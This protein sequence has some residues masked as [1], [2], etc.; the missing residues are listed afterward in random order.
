MDN[1]L[2]TLQTVRLA[3]N[4]GPRLRDVTLTVRPGVTAVMGCSGAGKT[5]LLNL[6]VDYERADSGTVL[7]HVERG[8][9]SL[10]VF[11]VPQ[12]GGLWPH[13]TAA[14]HLHAV[15][16]AALPH[17]ELGKLLT[18]FDLEHCAGARPDSLSMG[19]RSRLSVARAVAADAAALV[20]DEPLLHLDHMRAQAY[21]RRLRRHCRNS[22]T[23]LVF[24]THFP[25]AVLG[26]ADRVICLRE[27][28][29]LY[30]G[31]VDDLYYRPETQE[32][33]ECLGEVNWLEPRH[34]LL[35]LP[36]GNSK[37][38]CYRPEHI[39][40]QIAA[41]GPLEV[42]RQRFHGSV[43]R[44]TLSHRKTGKTRTFFHRPARDILRKGMRVALRLLAVL[45]IAFALN[46][47]REAEEPELAVAAVRHWS[48]PPEGA[49]IPG[50][51]SIAI[52]PDGEA[53]VLDT[54]GRVLIFEP[55][56][57]LRTQWR[58]PAVER[59][60]PEGVCVL[61]DGR[62]AVC[63]THYHRVLFFDVEGN[64]AGGFGEEGR[65]PGQFIYPVGIVQ[66]DEGDLYICEYGG[67][68]RVQKFT[69]DG[70]LLA[71]FGSSGPGPGEFQRP[72]GLAW[73]DG[74]LLVADAVNNRI[75]AFSEDGSL[76]GPIGGPALFD[77]P[78]GVALAPDGGLFVVEYGGGCVRRL[79]PDGRVVA[80]FGS[81]GYGAGQ[82]R[83]P[84]GLAADEGRVLV[85]DTG[86]RR[87]VEL[88]L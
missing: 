14:G 69:A 25:E 71:V 66:D 35:W 75:L 33:A 70:R 7:S 74:R 52:G 81:P 67:N 87:I 37:R 1:A 32:Q 18:G 41:D 28:E 43:A 6:L 22:G 54:A 44:V 62:I 84:W 79:S 58:M 36:E 64:Q 65:E 40:V 53:V 19:E 3:G 85:A 11:W 45:L 31:K 59:G 76:L 46:G 38:A 61:T 88:R 51:R 5:S 39:V 68:D 50:P 34:Q 55:D 56:G 4:S 77:L 72:S 80:T 30:E 8:D 24:S 57:R 78:Y 20:M 12:E 27:G 42:Q 15:R 63:D 17:S 83:T 16:P 21:R 60:R 26:E 86:N 48:M 23:S 13:L 82:F 73:R 47:C 10:P 29:V 49:K 9:H 2:W